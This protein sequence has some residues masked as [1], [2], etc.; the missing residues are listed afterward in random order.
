MQLYEDILPEVI[1]LK[2][3]ADELTKA[4]MLSEATDTNSAYV[5]VKSG[6]GGTE[7]CAWAAILARIYTNWAH[8]RSFTGT[9]IFSFDDICT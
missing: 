2:T 3:R 9:L 4:L 6:T 5:E 7:A 8:S 1:S